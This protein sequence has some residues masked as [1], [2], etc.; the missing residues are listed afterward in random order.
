MKCGPD[1]PVNSR[2]P[3]DSASRVSSPRPSSPA[4]AIPTP[5]PDQVGFVGS[6]CLACRA[7]LVSKSMRDIGLAPLSF[8]RLYAGRHPH[9]DLILAPYLAA[10]GKQ[11]N[12]GQLALG[13]PVAY[14]P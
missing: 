12:R 11:T 8:F 14:G 7:R 4:G 6:S 10:I 13:S 5:P 2:R 1:R 3:S 9:F